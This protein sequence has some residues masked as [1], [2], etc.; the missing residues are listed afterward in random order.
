MSHRTHQMFPQNSNI[1]GTVL[2]RATPK[3]SQAAQGRTIIEF[4]KLQCDG[5]ALT[6]H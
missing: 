5:D 3:P 2:F 6:D 4:F 1:P